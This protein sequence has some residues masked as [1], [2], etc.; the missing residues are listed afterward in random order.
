MRRLVD[1]RFVADDFAL[2]R[3]V[4]AHKLSSGGLFYCLAIDRRR[5]RSA[6]K[7]NLLQQDLGVVI[8]GHSAKQ[9]AF[10]HNGLIQVR[11]QGVEVGSA[12]HQL[13]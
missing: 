2:Q 9:G 4:V 6:D 8:A 5:H 7:L 3:R 11:P 12:K 13:H 10:E 1:P